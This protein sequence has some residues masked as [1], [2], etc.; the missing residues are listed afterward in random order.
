MSSV[1]IFAEKPDQSQ[2]QEGMSRRIED[3]DSLFSEHKRTYVFLGKRSAPKYVGEKTRQYYLN[4]KN[5]KDLSIFV[6]LILRHRTLY[7]HS[8]YNVASRAALSLIKIFG[9]NLIVDLHGAVPEELEFEGKLVEMA[10]MAPAEKKCLESARI[11]IC[12]SHAMKTHVLKKYPELN[13]D[14]NFLV[15]PIRTPESIDWQT[16]MLLPSSPIRV[17]YSGGAQKWQNV[18]EMLTYIFKNKN[19]ASFNVFTHEPAAF[20]EFTRIGIGVESLAPAQLISQ[21]Q[22]AH[23]GLIFRDDIL[24]NRVSCPTKL[25]EY[26]SMGIVP[27]LKSDDLGDFKQLGF[28]G[29]SLNDPIPDIERWKQMAQMNLSLFEKWRK[30]I[31]KESQKLPSLL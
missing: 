27:I 19:K 4:L 24:L 31:Q 7:T 23:F 5:I 10:A 25:M 28:K 16:K 26:L 2:A 20:E 6:G 13:V 11:I 1:L 8:I 14:T 12:V 21:Y 17:I 15:I 3:I 22:K 30:D 18:G 9:K 29:L